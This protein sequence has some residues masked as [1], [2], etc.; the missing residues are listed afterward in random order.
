MLWLDLDDE[1]LVQQGQ[2]KKIKWL[3]TRVMSKLFLI[4]WEFLK[5]NCPTCI[6]LVAE[7]NSIWYST[8]PKGMRPIGNNVSSDPGQFL[9]M[10]KA[11][12]YTRL[13][14]FC[15]CNFLMALTESDAKSAGFQSMPLFNASSRKD[16][17]ASSVSWASSKEDITS[18]KYQYWMFCRF[19]CLL[20]WHWSLHFLLGMLFALFYQPLQI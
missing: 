20:W 18:S 10:Q 1:C 14:F 7:K 2:Q 6:T 4:K 12:L 15:T 16:R 5:Q 11:N 17:F 13:F 3:G 19:Q 9:A 8:N